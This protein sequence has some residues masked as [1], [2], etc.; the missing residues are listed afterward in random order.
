MR[1]AGVSTVVTSFVRGATATW[2]QLHARA[3]G[4]YW[5]LAPHLRDRVHPVSA[6]AD[7]PWSCV[8]PDERMGEVRLG[9]RLHRGDDTC[10][11]LVHGL[12]GSAD[13]PYVRRAARAIAARGWSYLRVDLRGADGRGE[14]LYHAGLVGD[15]ELVVADPALAF[16]RTL[17][18]VGFSLGG[19]VALH[20][21]R[22]PCDAR[23]RAI[24][25]VCSPLDLARSAA[26]I[27]APRAT[28]YRTH[29]LR[30]LVE[31][32]RQVVARRGARM[33][34]TA[35]EIAAVRTI[36]DWDRVVVVP[37]HGF[38]DVEDY[39]RRASVAPHLRALELPAA[40][41]G[42]SWDPMVTRASVEPALRAAGDAIE[43]RWFERG[44]HVG[45]PDALV[46]GRSL[47]AELVRW[48]ERFAG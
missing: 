4:H 12:G 1:R 24:A 46:E 32:H 6:P 45:F 33:P 26:V 29:V 11:L 48:C 10:V 44:G 5:T 20:L 47:E 22:R 7:V 19:H 27:D 41:F 3:G 16:A 34:G 15:L 28:L 40:Y 23:L 21:G 43:V 39:W 31:G 9:G 42:A 18:V 37:R 25:A 35:A 38:A 30:A 36:R 14:D 2:S 17:L 13:S 8:V